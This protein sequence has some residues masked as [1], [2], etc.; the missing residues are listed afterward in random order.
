MAVNSD[1]FD[2]QTCLLPVTLVVQVEQLVQC[3]CVSGQ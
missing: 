1:G 2:Y 3:V